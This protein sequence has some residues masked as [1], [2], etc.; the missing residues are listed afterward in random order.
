LSW[1]VAAPHLAAAA[2]ILAIERLEV[3]TSKAHRTNKKGT[4]IAVR[5]MT[6]LPRVGLDA[7]ETYQLER[8]NENYSQYLLHDG[9]R[10]LR[11]RPRL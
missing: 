7:D 6:D 4:P 8:I 5:E 10:G 9:R 11:G 2:V 3:L 1:A